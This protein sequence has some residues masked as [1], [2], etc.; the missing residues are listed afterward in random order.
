M[1]NIIKQVHFQLTRSCN[2]R[3][4]FCGQWGKKGFFA[5]SSG[6]EM[7]LSDWMRII[8]ELEEYRKKS[9]ISPVVTLWGGEPLVSPCFDEIARE[10]K[11]R[12]FS[13]ELI[14]NGTRI[15]EHKDVIKSCI[16]RVY[17]SLDG[18]RKTHNAIRGEGVF[19][20]VRV[21]LI[22]LEHTNVTVMSVITPS[23]IEGIDEFLE[24]LKGIG[25]KNLF[26]QNMIGLTLDEI[27]NY[28]MWM[29][30]TFGIDAKEIE[31][32]ETSGNIDFTKL[33]GDR[34]QHIN[35]D[36]V[37]FE[38]SHKKHTDDKKIICKSPFSHA[39]IAWNGN[40]LF[41]TDFYDFSAGNVK[42]ETLE[43]IFS[44]EKSEMF[45]REIENSNCITCNHCS[46]R[47]S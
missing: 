37:P 39:H 27:E 25:I 8:D 20:K 24:E 28:K 46:W 5:D 43:N 10:L 33:L 45:R 34:L 2:L 47:M 6:E 23:M 15:N 29:K 41:C 30:S 18:D 31:A 38:I 44:N 19:E 16:D 14:T 4:S 17:V 21:N 42:E 1:E 7:T 35:L 3:C 13:L 26:L 32:W 36:D 11:N 22:E 9:G 12:G 40:V